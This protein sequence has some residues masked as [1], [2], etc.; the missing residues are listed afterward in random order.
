MDRLA[1]ERER[2]QR[3]VDRLGGEME[4]SRRRAGERDPCAY[5]SPAAADDDARLA[6]LAERST[7]AAG[8]LVEI[9][10]AM[11]RLERDEEGFFRC[12]RCAAPIPDARLDLLPQTRLCAA[13]AT[14]P[15]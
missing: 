14:R 2:V 6:A 3:E 5:R 12:D 13:C 8:T 15:G 10:R 4:E 11:Q 9:E 7:V 1:S